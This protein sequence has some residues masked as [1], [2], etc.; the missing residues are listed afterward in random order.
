VESLVHRAV[1]NAAP[2]AT[3]DIDA[4]HALAREAA[5][6]GIVLLKNEAA[7]LPLSPQ[8]PAIAVIGEQA[9]TPRYQGGGSSLINPTRLDNALAEITA[10]A[11][12]EVRY[13][14]G[15]DDPE[16]AAAL[17]RECS[18]AIVF[19]GSEEETEG[20]DRTGLE[21]P[22]A[23]LALIERVAAA[24]PRTVVVLSN[25]AVVRTAPWDAAVPALVEGWLLGQAGGGA[26]ADVLFGVVNPSGRLAETIPLRLADHPSHLDF[27]GEQGHVRYGEGIHVGYRG[28]D[29]REQE[30]AYPFGFGLSYTTFEYSGLSVSTVDGGLEVR[31]TVA[32]TGPRDGREVVQVYTGLGASRVRRAPRE[33]KAFASVPIAA[34]S[35]AAV[36]LRVDAADLAYW[37][38]ELGRW[39][40]EAGQ[41]TVEVGASSR[42]IRAT[43]TVA[44]AGD[45]ERRVLT[46][47]STIAEWF[48]DPRGAQALGEAFAAMAAAGGGAMAQTAADPAMFSMLASMPLARVAAFA[49]DAFGPDTMAALLKAAN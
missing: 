22:A 12:G 3:Y 36:V 14:A 23:H 25:G 19:A 35:S 49:G 33:L 37:D 42:D 34:G 47:E 43:A 45:D 26:V 15:Y 21:L 31:V 13:A 4:H 24:N 11:G 38:V 17:A 41:Y 6:R 27:P 10:L 20:S 46:P 2:G 29:A 28:F 8:E 48:A 18:V 16:G 7:L 32:N 39:V 30:V 5:G 1:A 44:V 40:V 9:R